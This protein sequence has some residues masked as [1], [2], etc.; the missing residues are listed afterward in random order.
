MKTFDTSKTQRGGEELSEMARLGARNRQQ[1]D[2]LRI[3]SGGS[4]VG[5]G[6]EG[7][8][9]TKKKKKGWPTFSIS[10]SGGDGLIAATRTAGKAH[11]AGLA[12]RKG[13]GG[14]EGEAGA[15]WATAPLN[16]GGADIGRG[17]AAPARFEKTKKRRV[18]KSRWN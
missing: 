2:P 5:L 7:S 17:S 6:W 9:Q 10:G 1:F 16:G 12:K 3:S 8:T 18:V 15:R 13:K 11:H 14:V 4:T